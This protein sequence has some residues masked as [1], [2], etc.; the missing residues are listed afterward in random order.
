MSNS[1]KDGLKV[2]RSQLDIM[3]FKPKEK[4]LDVMKLRTNQ[5]RKEIHKIAKSKTKRRSSSKRLKKLGLIILATGAAYG[6]IGQWQDN[7]EV[8]LEEAKEIGKT[9]E[10][11]KITPEQESQYETI[12]Q[13]LDNE[14]ATE[15]ELLASLENLEYL[16]MD[17]Q[18]TKIANTMNA[19]KEDITL[20]TE[21]STTEKGR[22]EESI[23]VNGEKY[24]NSEMSNEM[25]SS[26]RDL[27][28]LMIYNDQAEQ[29]LISKADLIKYGKK[30]LDKT[31]K[32]AA[33]EIEYENGK[34]ELKPT[35]VKEVK[36]A[37]KEQ[38]KQQ[39]DFER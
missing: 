19:N 29:R 2:D 12:K 4:P 1:F 14:S 5:P 28:G 17:M 27:A 26:I 38:Q 36:E 15:Y 6:G 23:T 35:R 21:V 7:K 9:V 33:S 31:S 39:E 22:T 32:M 8:T 30:Y 24:R 34:I 18:K 16:N 37:K 10:Q 20:F 13:M 3:Q 11:L 25:A